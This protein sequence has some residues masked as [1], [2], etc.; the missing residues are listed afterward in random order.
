MRQPLLL[1]TF[2]LPILTAPALADCGEEIRAAMVRAVTSGPYHIETVITM[3]DAVSESF[4]D[5]VPGEAMRAS[6][7]SGGLRH[8]TIV[9]GEQAWMNTDGSWQEMPAGM[10]AS[11]VAALKSAT[12]DPDGLGDI[13][14]ET[15]LGASVADGREVLTY[16]YEIT[17]NGIISHSDVLVDSATGLPIRT[18]TQTN[19]SGSNGT[20]VSTYTYDAAITVEAPN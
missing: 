4:V 20:I 9:I 6:G 7:T 2:L 10:A 19:I 16:S 11:A 5:I 13:S 18:E 12:G 8:E 14:H 15:C 1:A 3:Q 17:S